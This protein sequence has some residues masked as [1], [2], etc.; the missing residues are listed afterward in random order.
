MIIIFKPNVPSTVECVPLLALILSELWKHDEF[1]ALSSSQ[2]CDIIRR[3]ELS[4]RSE[5]EVF[6]AVI[7]WVNADQP[8]RA[9]TLP[10]LLSYVRCYDLPPR[11]IS[12]QLQSCPLIPQSSQCAEMLQRVLM[13]LRHHARCPDLKRLGSADP[14]IYS[15]GGYLRY[16]LTCFECYNVR[17]QAWLHL[18][19]IPSPRSGLA[20]CATRGCVYLVGGRNNNEHTNID[21]PSLDCYDPASNEWSKKAPMSVPRNRVAVGVI[22]DMIYAVGGSY[23]RQMHNTAEK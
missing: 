13:D 21:A 14:V 17:T 11:F 3:D 2:L 23:N 19:D 12:S 7:R 22:D 15:A 20:A 8:A 1:T 4:V 5:T 18:K 9:F 16:S 6:N 10:E